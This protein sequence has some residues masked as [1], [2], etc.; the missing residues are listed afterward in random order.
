MAE[1]PV[2]LVNQFCTAWSSCKPGKLLSFMTPDAVFHNI[3]IGRVVGHDAIKGAF[4]AFFGM[5]DN[6]DFEVRNVAKCRPIVFAERVADRFC[7]TGRTPR[8]VRLDQ[9]VGGQATTPP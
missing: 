3:P 5:A 2:E 8:S 1:D 4:E 9:P 7:V 6:V